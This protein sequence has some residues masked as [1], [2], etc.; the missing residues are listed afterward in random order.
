MPQ[1]P[2]SQEEI[3]TLLEGRESAMP[4]IAAQDESTRRDIESRD[5]ATCG[6]KL[7]ARPVADVT[8]LFRG[9]QVTYEAWCRHCGKVSEGS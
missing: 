2:L 8:K 5:C 9:T 7:R 4:H 3:A 6:A 1:R